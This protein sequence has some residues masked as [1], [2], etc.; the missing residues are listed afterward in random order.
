MTPLEARLLARLADSGPVPFA[1]YMETV[2]YDPDHGYYA[3][4][5]PGS[6]YRTSPTLTP[7]FGRLLAGWLRRQWEALGSAT[8][9]VVEVGGGSGDLA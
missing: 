5:V 4:R 1:A 6:D 8:F 3:H 2:L 7:W 9:T